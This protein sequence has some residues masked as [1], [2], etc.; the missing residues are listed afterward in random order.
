MIIFNYGEFIISGLSAGSVLSRERKGKRRWVAVRSGQDP[1]SSRCQTLSRKSGEKHR[2]P[3]KNLVTQC[4][5]DPQ[6]KPKKI[7]WSWP[8]DSRATNL[9]Q[10]RSI[11]LERCT[12]QVPME[13]DSSCIKIALR[14]QNHW[15]SRFSDGLRNQDKFVVTSQHV[16]QPR[17]KVEGVLCIAFEIMG[18]FRAFNPKT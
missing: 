13:K 5:A 7:L 6:E 8:T 9:I 18:F 2:Q 3:E 4:I 10:I 11:T 16:G 14:D 17:G 15:V 12:R 1:A